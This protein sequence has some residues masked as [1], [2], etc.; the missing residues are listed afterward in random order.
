MTSERQKMIGIAPRKTVWIAI[1][2][3]VVLHAVGFAA[4]A[5]WSTSSKSS[6]VRFAGREQAF[7]LTLSLTQPQW[8]GESTTLDDFETDPPVV[9]EPNRARIGKHTYI[10]TP[11]VELSANDFLLDSA[12]DSTQQLPEFVALDDADDAELHAL[13]EPSAPK[14]PPTPEQQR[15]NLNAS[16]SAVMV[17][18]S[19]LGNTEETP[20]DLSQNAPPTYPSHAIQKGWEGTVLLRVW[21]DEAGRITKVKVVRTSGYPILD[22]AAATA[23]RQWSA[24]PANRGDKPVTTIELLPVRFKL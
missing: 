20:P 4:I 6:R 1:A 21:I 14:K 18:Q 10:Q 22:G 5:T 2:T 19:T 13:T 8:E 15:T 23:V 17:P 11:T 16:S 24:I 7:Q 9:I 12:I 3:S